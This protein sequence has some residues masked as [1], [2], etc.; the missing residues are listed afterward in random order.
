MRGGAS[1][2]RHVLAVRAERGDA[3]AP[4][5]VGY[6]QYRQRASY[7]DGLP[8]GSLEIIELMGVDLRAEATLWQY[9][10]RADL[11][12]RVT[13]WNAPVDDPLPWLVTD[14]RRVR[15][16]RTDTLWLRIGDLPA[17]LAA[18][19]Y[20]ADGALRLVVD[21]AAWDLTAEGGGHGR[22]VAATAEGAGAPPTLRLAL[23]VL[24]SLYLGGFSAAQLARGGLVHGTPQAIS[25][26]DRLFAS[27]TAPWCP[28]VF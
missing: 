15:R 27:A 14:P 1:R 21:G 12:P 18:R 9:A 28:E 5:P 16:R 8:T 6:L 19:R 24:A 7:S 23:P 11:F 3:G 25:A 20:A 22:C 26:A 10:L 2:R 4:R 13:W 17:A